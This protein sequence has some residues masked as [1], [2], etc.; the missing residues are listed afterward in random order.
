MRSVDSTPRLRQAVLAARDLE[1]AVRRLRDEFGLGEPFR[2]PGVAHFGLANAVFAVGDTF[3]EVVSPVD[4]QQPGARTAA[5]QLERSGGEVCGYMVMLQ[6]DDLAAA[7]ER[8]R[9][10]GV[11]EVFEV[12]LEDISEVHLHP[13]DVRGAIV[14]L[15]A[16][17]PPDS[18][19]WGGPGWQQRAVAGRLTGISIAVAHPDVVARRWAEIAGAA[20]PG[21]AFMQDESSPGLVEIELEL[22]G[23]ERTIRPG[24]LG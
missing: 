24:Q 9:A 22:E 12:E 6:V 15:S 5:G 20:V 11:R 19:R 13:G 23:A 21:C 4:P 8:A 14:S 3:L 16:P 2:D 1:E 10:I 18:W 7:R 17:R